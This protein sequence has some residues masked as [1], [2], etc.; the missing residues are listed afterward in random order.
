M[1]MSVTRGK[2]SARCPVGSA[3]RSVG[4]NSARPISPRSK[5]LRW[6]ANT[7]Q[8]T[9]TAAICVANPEQTNDVQKRRKSRSW[10]AGG[11]A[12]TVHTLPSEALLRSHSAAT[13]RSP[14]ILY[15]DN[16]RRN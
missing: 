8:P 16:P 14:V 1:T 7:C 15:G 4:A 13:Q 11:R 2:R 12:G 6:I 3:R 5:A 9:A 10:S